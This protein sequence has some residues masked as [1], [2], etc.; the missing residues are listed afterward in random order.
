MLSFNLE[1]IIDSILSVGQIKY[2]LLKILFSFN[3]D[4]GKKNGEHLFLNSHQLI[5]N[6]MCT[7]L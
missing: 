7:Q 6:Q 2:N 3:A 4:K 5:Y 1:L